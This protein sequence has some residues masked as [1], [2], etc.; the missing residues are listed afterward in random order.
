MKYCQYCKT[1]WSD[2]T[3]T[4]K[5][6]GRVLSKVQETEYIY[7][8]NDVSSFGINFISFLIPLVGLILY[9][10]HHEKYPT[11]AS[12]AGTWAIIGFCV[13]LI[14]AIFVACSA[15]SSL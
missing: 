14:S 11:K 12:G 9:I 10:I 15:I 5:D 2:N 13:S 4:C 8:P 3:I 6:C 1:N 7:N